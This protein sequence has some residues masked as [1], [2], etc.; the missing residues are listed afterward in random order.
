M[1]EWVRP[2]ECYFARQST[3]G[4]A[5]VIEGERGVMEA[6]FLF[7]DF[8]TKA[9]V[10]LR[11]C[12]VRDEPSPL[13]IARMMAKDPI[14]V[15][16]SAGGKEEVYLGL[17]RILAVNEAQIFR[18][19]SLRLALSKSRCL[20]AYRRKRSSESQDHTALGKEE[21]EEVME[22]ED[23]EGETEW[24]LGVAKDIS[25]M[26]DIVLNQLFTPLY[27]PME[28]Y[29]EGFYEK[30]GST[31]LSAHVQVAYE[32]TPGDRR[33][34][35]MSRELEKRIKER[36]PLLLPE[37]SSR[38]SSSSSISRGG[39]GRNLLTT[40]EIRSTAEKSI[41]DL[42]VIEV[43]RI[44]IRRTMVPTGEIKVQAT[45]ACSSG[46]SPPIIY[47]ARSEELDFFDVAQALGK[48]VLR[49]CR[50]NDALLLSTLLSSTLPHLRR[51]GFPVDKLL[52][53]AQAKKA[54][55]LTPKPQTEVPKASEEEKMSREMMEDCISRLLH[56]YPSISPGRMRQLVQAW[57]EKTGGNLEQMM[58]GIIGELSGASSGEKGPSAPSSTSDKDLGEAKPLLPPKSTPKE[59]KG[60]NESGGMLKSMFNRWSRSFTPAEEKKNP[61]SSPPQ[62]PPPAKAAATETL[63]PHATERLNRSLSGAIKACKAH[64]ENHLQ[65]VAQATPVRESMVSHCDSSVGMRLRRLHIPGSSGKE[66]GMALFVDEDVKDSMVLGDTKL[67]REYWRF[68]ALLLRLGKEVFD[69]DAKAIHMFYDLVGPTIAFHR[70]GTSALFF[71]LRYFISLHAHPPSPDQGEESGSSQYQATIYWYLTFCHE[72]A[73]HFVQPHNSQHEF[74]LSAFAERYMRKVHT[75]LGM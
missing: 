59:S 68:S 20:L 16:E 30:L 61:G 37:T 58:S 32:L 72:L 34:T 22:A 13:D 36:M 60:E 2:A 67:L 4:Q 3:Q 27:A 44:G 35:S 54:A 70:S 40:K 52:R 15:L 28:P 75:M 24:E 71:N 18:D 45:S 29:L 39:G 57:S 51:K 19:S 11:A 12:G 65:S 74:Y 48:M 21:E 17:L 64:D 66:D 1:I 25:L 73:H 50:L 38:F 43:P 42:R 41:R 14:K 47:V 5:S 7:I 63:D 8:G 10:F 31:W 56:H 53:A 23:E 69:L 49:T 33:E 9:N 6:L 26:D 62:T 55:S 46:S